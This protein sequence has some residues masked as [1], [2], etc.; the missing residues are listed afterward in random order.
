MHARYLIL[1]H[2]LLSAA[3]AADVVDDDGGQ[4]EDITI[5][6]HCAEPG[7]CRS[8]EEQLQGSEGLCDGEL[9]SFAHVVVTGCGFTELRSL[10]PLA[11]PSVWFDTQTGSLVGFTWVSDTEPACNGEF[12][13]EQRP[14][15]CESTNV[16][17]CTICGWDTCEWVTCTQELGDCGSEFPC[18]YLWACSRETGCQGEECVNAD[19]CPGFALDNAESALV[20]LDALLSCVETSGCSSQCPL[21]MRSL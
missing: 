7:R 15:E 16:P 13:G 12:V 21:S 9:D 17:E 4:C 8:L 18:T 3:C 2:V 5:E 6:T 14:A 1:G 11:S 10:G 20:A 19:V